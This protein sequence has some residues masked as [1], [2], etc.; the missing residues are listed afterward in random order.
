MISG[1]E[2]NGAEGFMEKDHF[3]ETKNVLFPD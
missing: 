3:R 2:P 1:L